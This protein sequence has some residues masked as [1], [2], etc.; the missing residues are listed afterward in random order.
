MVRAAIGAVLLLGAGGVLLAGEDATLTLDR[1]VVIPLHDRNGAVL[2]RTVLK[3][4]RVVKRVAEDDASWTISFIGETVVVPKQASTMTPTGGSGLAADE[5]P[6][7]LEFTTIND[8][9]KVSASPS[10]EFP[11][12]FAWNET[13]ISPTQCAFL[14]LPFIKQT[15]PGI[16]TAAAAINVVRYLSPETEISASEMFRIMTNASAGACM[17]EV[18][19]GL[20]VLGFSGREVSTRGVPWRVL[21]SWVKRSLD[22]NLPILAAD[23]R[24]MVLIN[25][26]DGKRKRLFVWNQ[27]GNGKV[28]NGMPKGT[29][30]LAESDLPLEFESLIFVERLRY[31]PA[32]PTREFVESVL[33]TSEDLEVHPAFCE[34]SAAA[35]ALSRGSIPRLKAV[36]RGGRMLLLPQGKTV[37]CVAPNAL[38]TGNELLRGEIFPSREP[39]VLTVNALAAKIC[40]AGGTFLS[41]KALQEPITP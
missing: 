11:A 4:G 13:V 18:I 31:E 22:R 33:P 5:A 41:A 29:Y 27:W 1:D 2:G 16:C 37:L 35:G 28:I 20:R 38:K 8:P 36:L 12:G 17:S 32:K 30:E 25:G 24:H 14:A 15:K 26:Y 23:V 39:T 9:P 7:G 3:A 6:A 40:A 34:G 10:G 21:V 19:S